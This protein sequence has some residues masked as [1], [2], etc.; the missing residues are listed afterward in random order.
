ME[1]EIW[2]ENPHFIFRRRDAFLIDAPGM[3]RAMVFGPRRNGHRTEAVRRAGAPRR[4]QVGGTP[5]EMRR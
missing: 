1:N 3:D 2:L 4:G 5:V